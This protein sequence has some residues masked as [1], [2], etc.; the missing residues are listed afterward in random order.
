MLGA[1]YIMNFNTHVSTMTVD[2]ELSVFSSRSFFSP[3]F[4]G[5]G[6]RDLFSAAE[7]Y[8]LLVV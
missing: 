3:Q 6:F 4:S 1:E 2:Y 8:G 5:A 7:K